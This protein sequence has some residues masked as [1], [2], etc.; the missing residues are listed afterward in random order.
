M[1]KYCAVILFVGLKILTPLFYIASRRSCGN[2]N[3]SY[4]NIKTS[5]YNL[6]PSVYRVNGSLE[7]PH[8]WAAFLEQLLF[9]GRDQLEKQIFPLFWEGLSQY[10]ALKE[11]KAVM[12]G[13]PFHRNRKKNK[14]KVW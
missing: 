2:H 10:S 8:P 7:T 4:V 11:L 12:V 6:F 5:Q 14:E 3:M 9:V 13:G 1:D